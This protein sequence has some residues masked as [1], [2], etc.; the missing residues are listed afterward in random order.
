MVK[1][2]SPGPATSY[3]QSGDWGLVSQQTGGLERPNTEDWTVASQPGGPSP[4]G[5]ADY[6]STPNPGKWDTTRCISQ[7]LLNISFSSEVLKS[8]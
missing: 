5:P 1:G 7:L 3:Q 6:P 8:T 2:W 4:E